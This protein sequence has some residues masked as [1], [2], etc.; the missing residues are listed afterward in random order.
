MSVT[1]KMVWSNNDYL[2][3]QPCYEARLAYIEEA[4]AAGKTDGIAINI[5]ALET[6]RTWVD[7]TAADEWIS[8]INDLAQKNGLSVTVTTV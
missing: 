8:F 4:K 2:S 6:R 1:T 3:N 5:G 7:Q